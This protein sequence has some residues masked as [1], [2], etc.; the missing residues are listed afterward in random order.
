MIK[1][2]EILRLRVSHKLYRQL[3]ASAKVAKRELP[4]YVRVTLEEVEERNHGE[5]GKSKEVQ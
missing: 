2:T 5:E 4:D 3:V 1:L